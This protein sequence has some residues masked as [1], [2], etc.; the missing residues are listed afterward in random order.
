MALRAGEVDFLGTGFGS[1]SPSSIATL[2]R[3][4]DL[5]VVTAEGDVNM[6]IIPNYQREPLGNTKVRRAICHAIDKKAISDSLF[7]GVF[8]PAKGIFSTSIPYYGDALKRDIVKGYDY[9]PRLSRELLEQAGWSDT[10]GDGFVDNGE[11]NMDLVLVIPYVMPWEGMPVSNQKSLAEAVKS[12]LEAAGMHV[13]IRAEEGGQWWNSVTKTYDYDLYLYGPWGAPYD[14][15]NTIMSYWYS[16]TRLHYSD[17]EFDRM[18]D[19][20]LITMDEDKRQALY[21]TIF[22]YMEEAALITPLFQSEMIFAYQEYVKD[23]MIP[24][25]VYEYFDLRKASV[26]KD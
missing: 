25:A 23:F 4:Q 13:T 21:D 20:V 9:D 3:Q 12:Y 22:A 18:M 16:N 10:D 17:S 5:R 1:I 11:E 6:F 2:I 26:L 15:Q 19:Q 14:P 7:S 8:R 24:P